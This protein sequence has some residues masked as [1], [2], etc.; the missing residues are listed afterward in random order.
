[1]AI[2]M[3]SAA[4]PCMGGVYGVAL[5]QRANVGV[6][7]VDVG[8]QAPAT[9]DGLHPTIALCLHYCLV[10]IL[11]NPGVGA[12]IA[13]NYLLRLTH[14]DVVSHPLAQAKGANAVDDAEVGHLRLASLVGGH[15]LGGD[16]E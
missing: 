16:V 8:Q 1:M 4:L 14:R 11:L 7:G 12:E 6:G 10:D 5:C 2:F 9:K 15:L 3:M 13:I